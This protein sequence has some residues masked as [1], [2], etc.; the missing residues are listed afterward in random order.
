MLKVKFGELNKIETF[1]K[2]VDDSV[3]AVF[4][5]LTGEGGLSRRC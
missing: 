1:D 4:I 3:A 2:L 5:E